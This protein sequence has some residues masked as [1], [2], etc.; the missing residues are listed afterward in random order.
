MSFLKQQL[1]YTTGVSHLQLKCGAYVLESERNVVFRQEKEQEQLQFKNGYMSRD[2][3]ESVQSTMQLIRRDGWILDVQR[4]NGTK[5]SVHVPE[6]KVQQT[7]SYL[8]S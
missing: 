6:R 4:L 5:V 2:E 8:L 7:Y 1:S 3:D